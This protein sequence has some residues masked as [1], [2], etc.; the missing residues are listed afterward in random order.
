[1]N[2]KEM[3]WCGVE[4]VPLSQ[5]R[6]KWRA[7]VIV[8]TNIR[9]SRNREISRIAEELLATQEDSSVWNLLLSD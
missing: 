1:M 4:F 2:L 9:V 7:P 8:V 5:K 3:G 6:Y